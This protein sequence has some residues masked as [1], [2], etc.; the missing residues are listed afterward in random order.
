MGRKAEPSKML[1]VRASKDMVDKVNRVSDTTGL[2][3]SDVLRVGINML[4]E[5]VFEKDNKR[6]E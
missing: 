5:K 2:S 4:H 6:G 3:V 1:N